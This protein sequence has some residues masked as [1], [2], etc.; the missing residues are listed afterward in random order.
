LK[1]CVIIKYHLIFDNNHRHDGTNYI[2]GIKYMGD[3]LVL[4]GLLEDDNMDIV[5]GIEFSYEVG[6]ERKTIITIR[7]I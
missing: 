7:S 5:K 6:K 1:G 2:G 4:S 3:A